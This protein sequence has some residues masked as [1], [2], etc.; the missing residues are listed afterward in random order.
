MKN[1]NTFLLF[2]NTWI[3]AIEH[4]NVNRYGQFQIDIKSNDWLTQHFVSVLL[5]T[6]IGSKHTYLLYKSAYISNAYL[7]MF[8]T[9][10]NKINDTIRFRSETAPTGCLFIDIYEILNLT[11]VHSWYWADLYFNLLKIASNDP[12]GTAIDVYDQSWP[13]N[14]C[15]MTYLWL[16]NF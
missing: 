14:I 16:Q 6:C 5:C 8:L 11:I 9:S 13:G 7:S 1:Y 4:I 10:H 2:E 12:I 3:H 15:W